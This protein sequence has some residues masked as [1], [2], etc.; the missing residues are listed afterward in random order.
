MQTAIERADLRSEVPSDVRDRFEMVRVT[1]TYA[2]FAYEL[3]SVA[4]AYGHLLYEMALGERFIELYAR[5]IPLIHRPSGERTALEVARFGDIWRALHEGPRRHWMLNESHAGWSVEGHTRFLGSLPELLHWAHGAGLLRSW[6]AF[7]WSRVE[8]G[9]RR[10][11]MSTFGEERVIPADYDSWDARRRRRWWATFRDSWQVQRLEHVATG[12]HLA[13]HPEGG[14]LHGP[15]TFAVH[16]LARF[17][18]SLW[19]VTSQRM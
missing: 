4:E 1:Y 5:R 19:S 18:N 9:V 3:F 11:A 13:A 17:I 16:D 15:S 2:L 10:A 8:G 6:L 7:E 14:G 12:R